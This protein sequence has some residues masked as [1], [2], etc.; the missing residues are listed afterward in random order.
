MSLLMPN[1]RPVGLRSELQAATMASSVR[2]EGASKLVS[3]KQLIS[4]WSCMIRLSYS[5]SSKALRIFDRGSLPSED[6]C[7]KN[8]LRGKTLY[9]RA[10][11]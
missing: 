11:Q 8:S 5:P 6:F 7:R 9:G 10:P 1:G 3:W 2:V 4:S